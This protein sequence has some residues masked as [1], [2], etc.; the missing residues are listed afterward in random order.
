MPVN[1]IPHIYKDKSIS[2]KGDIIWTEIL[3]IERVAINGDLFE[4][5]GDLIKVLQRSVHLKKVV[6]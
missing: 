6:Q 2:Y 5:G 4:I 3:G 1:D